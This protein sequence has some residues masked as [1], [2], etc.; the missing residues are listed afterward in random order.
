MLRSSF[1]RGQLSLVSAGRDRQKK[2]S[3]TKPL[4]SYPLESVRYLIFRQNK[5]IDVNWLW[6]NHLWRKN[7]GFS[8]R[9]NGA[10]GSQVPI[11]PGRPWIAGGDTRATFTNEAG[12]WS[13]MSEIA[14]PA[15]APSPELGEAGNRTV[16]LPIASDPSQQRRSY[17][18]PLTWKHEIRNRKLENGNRFCRGQFPVC[19][20]GAQHRSNFQF[21]CPPS[22]NLFGLR[23]V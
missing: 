10:R 20:R 14:G 18:G 17:C 11:G 3:Q 13:G 15:P 16:A 1:V 22:G 12:M 9:M 4:A 2:Q 23:L 8:I 19:V 6:I 7:G 21:P 5:A